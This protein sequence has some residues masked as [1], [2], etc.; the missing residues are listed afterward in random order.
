[1]LA[2]WKDWGERGRV[3]GLGESLLGLVRPE[4]RVGT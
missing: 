2:A 4:T 3:L 1:M